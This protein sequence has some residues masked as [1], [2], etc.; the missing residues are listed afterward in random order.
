MEILRLSS[1]SPIGVMVVAVFVGLLGLLS[2]GRLPLQLF[3]D[4]KKPELSIQ[5]GWRTPRR[6]WAADGQDLIFAACDNP[7]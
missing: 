6:R 3:P 1:R 2:L 7:P 5:A 4:V